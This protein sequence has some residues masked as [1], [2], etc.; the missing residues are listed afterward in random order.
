M[1]ALWRAENIEQRDVW[2]GMWHSDRG[3]SRRERERE[4][5]DGGVSIVTNLQTFPVHGIVAAEEERHNEAKHKVKELQRVVQ[6][7]DVIIAQLHR[8][9]DQLQQTV[10]HLKRTIRETTRRSQ[11]V[12]AE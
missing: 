3:L 4:R 8:D 7:K 2:V 6:E 12:N 10:A 1:W 5:T 9:Y 11:E